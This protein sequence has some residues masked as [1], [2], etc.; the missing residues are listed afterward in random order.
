MD[1]FYY[2]L[3][4]WSEGVNASYFESIR[5]TCER[6]RS[7]Q[8]LQ[9]HYKAYFQCV[10]TSSLQLL[11]INTRNTNYCFSI[12]TRG[13]WRSIPFAWPP[14]APMLVSID[15]DEH[16][17]RASRSSTALHDCSLSP[18][19][20]SRPDLAKTSSD[21]VVQRLVHC[22]NESKKIVCI[23]GAGISVS[24]GIPDFRSAEGLYSR[25][26][27]ADGD[28]PTTKLGTIK[29]R[30]FFDASFFANPS[31]RPIFYKFLAELQSMCQAGAP[32]PTHHFLGTLHADGRLLRWY[33]QNIDGLEKRLGL[34]LS[35]DLIPA[36]KPPVVSLH[37]TMEQLSCTLCG[38]RQPFDDKCHELLKKGNAPE[39]VRC[40]TFSSQRVAHGKRAVKTGVMR[41]DIVLYN[42]PH[43]QGDLIAEYLAH[44]TARRPSLL[45]VM[46]T[47]LKVV[48]LKK[49]VKDLA[50]S[51]HQD[52]D[53]LVVFI[54]KTPAA[55][56][57]W[58]GT[59][60]YELV[61]E[62]DRWI[63]LLQRGYQSIKRDMP[64]VRPQPPSVPAQKDGR[65][66]KMFRIVRKVAH[67]PHTEEIECKEK[68]SKIL[69][70]DEAP[71]FPSP[72]DA[73]SPSKDQ[74]ITVRTSFRVRAAS[75][76]L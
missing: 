28:G 67:N 22:L 38:H 42:E 25:V 35:S 74:A 72:R 59:F 37:G 19:R 16:L 1:G 17:G 53:G 21:A 26:L 60:D 39:C 75:V 24:A 18:T 50:R 10:P 44:D 65:I 47:S 33:T 15:I 48:G 73:V 40:F 56:S 5:L 7:V 12:A 49:M 71:R 8:F 31:T 27:P 52:P 36:K 70:R 61:G 34:S 20:S 3:W 4:I 76:A 23:T 69:H 11:F 66:D 45:L 6:T 54:N 68:D 2:M 41:P 14:L 64:V 43:P 29:G 30:D 13:D 32:T 63:A 46:G 58:R 9:C 51:V 55:R 57:E 62:C